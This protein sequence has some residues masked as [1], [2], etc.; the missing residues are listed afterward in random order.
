MAKDGKL[1]TKDLVEKIDKIAK[2]RMAKE[3][4]VSLASYRKL[5]THTTTLLVIEDDE[6][7]RK[8]IKRIFENENY[9]VIE[10]S[11]GTQLSQVLGDTLIDL[12]ILD[13]G[14]PWI[15]GYE[16]ARL[17]KE[18]D[19]LKDLHLVFVSGRTGDLDVKRGFA[20]GADDYIKKPFKVDEI[21]RSVQ[22]LL[23]LKA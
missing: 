1:T 22:T 14:L 4:V 12:I 2:E 9:K 13:I 6:T 21:K 3:K 11:D 20:V 7:I 10:A 5:K 15:D 16:L 19:D 18:N 23:E 17:M 8:A